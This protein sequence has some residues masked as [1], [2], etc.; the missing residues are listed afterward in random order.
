MANSKLAY[1]QSYENDG[2]FRRVRS[3]MTK[4]PPVPFDYIADPIGIGIPSPDGKRSG[5]YPSVNRCLVCGR[6]LSVSYRTLR[7][8]RTIECQGC[9]E[10][11]KLEDHTPIGAVQRLIDKLDPGNWR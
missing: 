9:G 10:T 5:R 4:Q 2:S 7:L 8:G 3:A 11:I 1:R 6:D